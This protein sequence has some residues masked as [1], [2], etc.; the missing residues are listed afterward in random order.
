MTHSVILLELPADA[1]AAEGETA[2]VSVVAA[3]DGL[4]YQWYCKNAGDPEFYLS[5]TSDDGIYSAVMDESLSGQQVYCLM[6]DQH[7]NAVTTNTVT[8]TMANHAAITEQPLDVTVAGGETAEVRVAATGDG[9]TYQWYFKNA[10]DSEFSPSTSVTGDTYAVEM[11]ASRDCRQVYCVIT[12]QYGNSVTSDTVTLT[13]IHPAAI[14]EQSAGVTVADGETAEVSVKA[15]GDGLTY[16]WY[17]K[18]AGDKEFALTDVFTGDTYSITMNV[19]RAGR[20]VYC[21]I[22]DQHGNSVTSDTVTLAMANPVTIVKQPG[23]VT[24]ADGETAKVS[25]KAAGDGLTYQ[26][27]FKN[28]GDKEFALTDAFAGDTYSITMNADRAGRQVYCV[29]TDQYGNTV[30]S[31]TVTLRM[32]QP[33][34]ITKQPADVTVADGETAKVSVKATGDGLTYQWYFKNAGDAEF[35]RTSSFTDNT[36]FVEMSANRAGRQV[37][38]VITDQYGNSVTSDTVTLGRK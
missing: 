1:V 18:N 17:Y 31:D 4:M 8:L 5:E 30:T 27:Y 32:P 11:D 19:D 22:T 21:V 14:V 7:G 2:L 33:V 25:V 28:A 20:Q 6:I 26:W 34:T 3:G 15:E 16:Q 36:Y 24:V 10:G 12:D 37:Y 38:C 29:I 35:T 13:M 23:D 9:L